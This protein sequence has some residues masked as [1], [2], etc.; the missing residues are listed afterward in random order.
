MVTALSEERVVF[1]MPMLL[2]GLFCFCIGG[3]FGVVIAKE[4][5]D[6]SCVTTTVTP[7]PAQ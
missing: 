5:L 6:R 7:A 1:R 2:F 4:V 3:M